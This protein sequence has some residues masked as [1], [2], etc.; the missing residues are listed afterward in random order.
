MNAPRLIPVSSR[1]GTT[2]CRSIFALDPLIPCHLICLLVPRTGNAVLT[3]PV[4]VLDGSHLCPLHAAG[5]TGGFEDDSYICT[6]TLQFF[7][8]FTEHS[9]FIPGKESFTLDKIAS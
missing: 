1:P 6:K 5:G 4:D 9:P 3:V 8:D 2:A 7:T